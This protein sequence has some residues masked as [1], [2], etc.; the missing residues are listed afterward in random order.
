V[1]EL[2]PEVV[3]AIKMAI[4]MEKDGLRYYEQAAERTENKLAKKM[5]H[6]IAQDEV[7]HLKTFQKIFDTMTGSEEWREMAKFTPKV[8]EIPVFEGGIEKKGDVNP[9]DVDALRVAID[10]ERKGIEHYK[11]AASA[12]V[13]KMAKEIFNKIREEEEYH[14]DLLQAQLDYLTQSGFWFDIGE[15]QM[16]G[17]F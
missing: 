4:Q 13:D 11:K 1:A 8:G 16:D 12:A 7:I 9:S 15:I 5:F 10:N 3:E 6:K 14:Y 2:K 17:K